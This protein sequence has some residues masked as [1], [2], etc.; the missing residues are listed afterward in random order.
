MTSST[1]EQPVEEQ[2]K[3]RELGNNLLGY[4]SG[5]G[6]EVGAGYGTDLATAGLL[7]PATI[8][9]TGGLSIAGYGLIN[10]GSGATSNWAAQKLRGEEEISW[11]EIISSGLIDIIPFFGQKLK[12]AKGVANVAL[13]SG[14]RTVAQRQGEEA[15]DDQRWLTPRETLESAALGGAFGAGFK[16]AGKGINI[17]KGKYGKY[18]LSEAQKKF[19]PEVVEELQNRNRIADATEDMMRQQ[20]GLKM[21]LRKS[22]DPDLDTSPSEIQPPGVDVPPSRRPLPMPGGEPYVIPEPKLKT[23]KKQDTFKNLSAEDQ[24]KALDIIEPIDDF[25]EKARKDPL[26]KYDPSAPTKGA[27]DDQGTP[28]PRKFITADGK[29]LAVAFRGGQWKVIDDSL[30]KEAIKRRYVWAHSYS[31]KAAKKKQAFT[32][33]NKKEENIQA[34]RILDQLIKSDDPADQHLYTRLVG[35]TQP[36]QI[37]H[38]Q[39]QDSWVWKEIKNAKGEVVDY[40]HK[41]KKNADGTSVRPGDDENLRL[42]GIYDFK[43][44]KDGIEKKMKAEGY[45]GDDGYHLDMDKDNNIIVISNKTLK[46]VH[47]KAGPQYLTY[48][49]RSTDPKDGWKEFLNIIEGGGQAPIPRAEDVRR[50]FAEWDLDPEGGKAMERERTGE[51]TKREIDIEDHYEE[52]KKLQGKILKLDHTKAE[53][54]EEKLKLDEKLEIYREEILEFIRGNHPFVSQKR[55]KKEN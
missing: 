3:K 1:F 38:I 44:L 2:E 49:H 47:P 4:L 51:I 6:L 34:K 17:L 28:L 31:S 33:R 37:E 22:I 26:S 27:I 41:Y 9:A 16:G 30:A 14:A 29:A 11:G 12:G 55:L 43:Y 45:T 25:A 18:K 19:P 46:R 48:I 36:F 8:A 52:I 32:W 21:R 54:I 7:N 42:V 40:E 15:L 13:Q 39:N 5:T 10:F 20:A 23:L 24:Q 35:G 50:T 53:D